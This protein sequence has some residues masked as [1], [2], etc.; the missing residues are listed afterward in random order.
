M[1]LINSKNRIIQ[2]LVLIHDLGRVYIQT[3]P[4][5]KRCILRLLE[6]PVRQLGM[7]NTELMKLV[8]ACAKGSETLVTRVIHILTE[9]SKLLLNE[10]GNIALLS[11]MVA[12]F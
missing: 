12:L 4:D 5:V 10:L 2:I 1:L 3:G 11:I 9:R 6:G 8:E 7:E